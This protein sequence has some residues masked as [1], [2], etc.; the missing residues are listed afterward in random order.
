MTGS[1]RGRP[2]EPMLPDGNGSSSGSMVASNKGVEADILK[3]LLVDQE[4]I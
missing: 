3:G 2:V 1:A 4:V